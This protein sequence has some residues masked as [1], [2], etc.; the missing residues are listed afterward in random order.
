MK[1]LIDADG[2]PVV[3]ETVSIA[4][5]YHLECIILCDT[6]H[7]IFYEDATTKVYSKGAD[8][9]DFELIRW[10][11]SGDFVITQ[12]YGLAAMA[13]AREALVLNQDGREYTR[14]NIDGLL[15]MRHESK[16][17]RQS[18]IRVKGPKKRSPQQNR[19]FK[20]HLDHL[21]QLK[22]PPPNSNQ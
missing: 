4:K 7:E 10:I 5:K 16:K 17:M 15:A 6:S 12:D 18:R 8:S 9:V 13:L 14:D 21:C 22:V 1:I 19:I 2:C 11:D 3:P 20:E